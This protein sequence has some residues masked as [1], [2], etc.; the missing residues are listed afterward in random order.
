MDTTDKIYDLS[1]LSELYGDDQKALKHSVSVLLET[2]PN[3]IERLENA[4]LSKDWIAFFNAG[5][6]LISPV[7]MLRIGNIFPV[8]QAMVEAT[9]D[10]KYSSEVDDMFLQVLPVLKEAFIQLSKLM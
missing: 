10:G 9:R 4:F 3:D 2:L 5:H 1:Y 6:K 8:M 7:R